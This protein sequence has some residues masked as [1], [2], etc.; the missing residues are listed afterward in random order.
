MA[1]SVDL[2][3]VLPASWLAD[4]AEV[5]RATFR[6]VDQTF[7]GAFDL[8]GHVVQQ[9][10]VLG[11]AAVAPLCA[12]VELRVPEYLICGWSRVTFNPFTPSSKSTFSQP[13]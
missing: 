6:A 9:D 12:A 13:S 5:V 7:H 10:H 3:P 2:A 4:M 8:V 11:E 1:G